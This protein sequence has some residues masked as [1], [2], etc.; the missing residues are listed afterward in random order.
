MT[1]ILTALTAVLAL[2]LALV[3]GATAAPKLLENTPLAGIATANEVVRGIQ[4]GGLPWVV[5][6]G[7]NAKVDAE[8]N[9]KVV[10]HGLLFAPGTPNAGTR[11]SIDT[12]KATVVCA[13]GSLVDTATAPLS[14]DGDAQIRN[15]VAL[16]AGCGDPIVM[17]RTTGGRW[18]A[19]TGG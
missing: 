14:L 15:T 1:R 18:L 8:G 9:V 13:D 7:T 12:V 3:A 10:V 4:G 2:A 6:E 11:G 19:R 17:V 16:P 5:A